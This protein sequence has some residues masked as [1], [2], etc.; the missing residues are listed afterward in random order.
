M[1]LM[2]P[3]GGEHPLQIKHQLKVKKGEFINS[4]NKSQFAELMLTQCQL[5]ALF[6]VSYLFVSIALS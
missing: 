4:G 1:N 2:P 6:V 3:G 5:N